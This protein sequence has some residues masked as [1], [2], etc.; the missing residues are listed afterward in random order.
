VF[1]TDISIL[2]TVDACKAARS[3]SGEI[4]E[5]R[6]TTLKNQSFCAV[7]KPSAGF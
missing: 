5:L 6:T 7:H 2:P 4:A 1:D 3:G